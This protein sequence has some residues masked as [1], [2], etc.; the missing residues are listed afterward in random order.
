L[1]NDFDLLRRVEDLACHRSL[2]SEKHN[3]IHHSLQQMQHD[4]ALT[5]EVALRNE[6][7]RLQLSSTL[8]RLS[9][10]Q[11]S[12]AG[13]GADR[14]D[15]HAN[16]RRFR[17]L[18]EADFSRQHQVQYYASTLG[19]SEKTLS[20]VCLATT[21]V[22]AKAIISQR[23]TLEAKRLLSHTTLAVQ[24]IGRD[25]GFE[26]ATNFVKFFQKQAGMAPLAFRQEVQR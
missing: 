4:G 12:D 14:G 2:D 8:L 22:P 1:G 11:S 7:L 20:R 18:L 19:M 3:W 16:F 26:E 15:V 9:I 13:S 25:L 17:K 24:T 10:W 5:V 6:L 21:G 23:L